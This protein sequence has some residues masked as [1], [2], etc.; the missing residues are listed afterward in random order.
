M[1]LT[2]DGTPCAAPEGAT[3][4][5]AARAAG[6]HIPSLC[7]HPRT[8][9]AAKCRACVVH[10]EGM[11]PFQTA[12]SVPA[13]DGMVVRTDAPDLRA[14]QRLV[15]DLALASGRHDCLSCERCGSCELQDEAYRLGIET[16]TCAAPPEQPRDDSSESIRM[17]PSR[18]IKCGRC[19]AACNQLVQHEVLD[20][21]GRGEG[22][23]VICDE[24]V[25]MGASGCVRCGEC[26][27]V[28]PTGALV[29][30]PGIGQGRSWEL[31]KTRTIC[32]YCGV[33]CNLDVV[34]TAGDRIL[35]ALG[36]ETDWR[37]LPNQ[38]M[39]CVKGRFGLDFVN[40]PERLRAPMVR[41]D[42]VLVETGWDEALDAAARG[43]GA[44]RRDFGPR[45]LG[46]LSSAKVTNEENYAM[47]RF[48]RGVLGSNNIDHCARLCHASTVAG[49]TA[50]LGSGAMTNSMQEVMQSRV[51]L[52]IGS[53]T[54]WCHPVFGG[55]IKRAARE[56]GARIIVM[57]PRA[58][59]LAKVAEIHVRQRS[60]S[61]LA[62]LMGIQ[63]LIVREGWHDRAFIA[64]RC[65]GWD[66]YEKSLADF[67]PER[68]AALTGVSAAEL[69]AC[70]RLYA[71]GGTAAIYYG[72]G[73]TQ[74]THGVDNVKA[75]SNLALITGNLGLE[76]GGVNPL[77]GH[78]N[79]QGACDMGALPNVFTGYQPVTDPAV[80]A[81]FAAAWKLDPGALD[82]APGMA[83]TDM[84]NACG[85][86]IRALYIMGENP[87][88]SDPNLNHAEAQFRKLDFLVVQDIFL[89]ETARLADVVL[90][91]AS[92]AEKLGTYTNTERRVQIGRPVIQPL[93]GVR[94]DAVIIAQLAA[95][96]GC[97]DFPS[98]PE[99]LFEELRRLTPSYAGMTYP[100]LART[101]LRWPCP[102]EDH[103]GTPVLHRTAFTRGRGLLAPLAYRPPAEEPDQGYPFRLT[104]GRLLQHYHTGSMTRRARVLDRLA[105]DAEVE[106]HPSDAERLG[107]AQ[108]ARVEVATR[109]GRVQARAH[110]TARIA[111]GALFMSFHFAEAAANRLTSDA[112]DPVARI[113]EFKACAA[114]IAPVERP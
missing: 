21:G 94:Q 16:P 105:P 61:D 88:M 2:I 52:V 47:M 12:C 65:E 28:C 51:I 22:M 58:T 44:A 104:T 62:L 23:R 41:R 14:A 102:S 63:H 87:M 55:M 81:R 89:T 46:C 30:K 70:A 40:H 60:G 33:G 80:R 45:A 27:Q 84:V 73:I 26:A 13:R 112:L 17:D 74:S 85:D 111:R 83:V 113:P 86:G 110:V 101:G 64:A 15:I 3:V 114:R 90:P 92:F 24:D 6:I 29:F 32:P 97:A 78:S 49:L 72:M 20:F 42:G 69:L 31:R 37:D 5:E 108:G 76:G 19:V 79:V 34:S 35:Y 38:G 53:N 18:C 109:R 59:D 107:V 43:L 1:K 66:E 11:R 39:L 10:I 99:A 100:R 57:D 48:A 4:L 36:T 82:P 95:R 103:P 8:G 50:T 54:T 106:I 98:D 96:M 7:H 75:V 9:P 77:R 93:P 91:A 25:P 68:V 71:T 67:T 56:G